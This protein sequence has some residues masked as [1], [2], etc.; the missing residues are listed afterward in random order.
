M[1]LGPVPVR[2]AVGAVLVHTIRAGGRV[3]KK[4]HVLVPADLEMLAA[5]DHHEVV[6]ARL[7]PGELSEDVAAAAIAKAMAG[8]NLSL[9]HI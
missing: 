4:G 5:A 2:E 7:E 1:K 9:I 3:L 8:S 6:C